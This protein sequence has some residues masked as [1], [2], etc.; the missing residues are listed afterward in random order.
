[1]VRR[2]TASLFIFPSRTRTNRL[3]LARESG[4][5]VRH[6]KVIRQK[7]GPQ[8][9]ITTDLTSIQL[10]TPPAQLFA[11]EPLKRGKE[12]DDVSL[13]GERNMSLVGQQAADFTLASLDGSPVHL[14][15]L[16]GKV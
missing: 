2:W 14:G 8:V 1:M 4:F 3:F 7:Q 11:F 16:Q 6:V 13:P 12:V 10:E 9:K 15:A 5:A